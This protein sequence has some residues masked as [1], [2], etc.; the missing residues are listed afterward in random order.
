M[1]DKNI[2][3]YYELKYNITFKK[4]NKKEYKNTKRKITK[5]KNKIKKEI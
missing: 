2:I 4:M 5:L 3:K 1:I